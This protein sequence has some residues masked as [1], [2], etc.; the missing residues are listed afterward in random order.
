MKRLCT[1]GAS[2]ALEV[3]FWKEIHV[4]QLASGIC[5]RACRMLGCCKLEKDP[6]I[7][8]TLYPKSAAKLLEDNSGSH[9][10]STSALVPLQLVY[11]YPASLFCIG[12]VRLLLHLHD[13]IVFSTLAHVYTMPLHD[14]C[15][16][17]CF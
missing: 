12:E 13:M 4:L 9:D 16:T 5:G 11:A 14:A 8:M 17:F 3:A 2:P 15:R 1:S 7:V 10:A 6:C